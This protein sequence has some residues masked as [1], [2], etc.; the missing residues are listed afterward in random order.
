[1]KWKHLTDPGSEE[2]YKRLSLEMSENE[3]EYKNSTGM[4]R[5]IVFIASSFWQKQFFD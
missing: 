3:K 2:R 4:P 1:M 5:V